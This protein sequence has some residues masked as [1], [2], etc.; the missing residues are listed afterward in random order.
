M[1][2]LITG[3]P[4]SFKTLYAMDLLTKSD[5]L[6]RPVYSNIDG[7]A[8]LPIPNND[9]R[10][11][12]EG[13]LVIYDEAQGL[14]PS[15]GKAG[16][17]N[18]PRIVALDQHRHTGHDIIFITQRYTLIH[19]HI[20]GFVGT[21]YHLVRKTKSIATLYTN[22]EVFNPDDKK[23]IRTV[24]TSIF[25]APSS[26]FNSYKSASLHTK[27]QTGLRFPKWLWFLIFFIIIGAYF[28]YSAIT[29]FLH[30]S[31][32]PVVV[33]A[34]VSQTLSKSFTPVSLA[35]SPSAPYSPDLK[36]DEPPYI[37]KGY[38][39]LKG[40]IASATSCQCFDSTG[41]PVLLTSDLCKDAVKSHGLITLAVQDD[42]HF[43]NHSLN[44]P[45]S[46][47]SSSLPIAA[48]PQDA[49]VGA[50]AFPSHSTSILNTH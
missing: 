19:H 27:I 45:T 17:S 11:T 7:A 44:S 10:D 18:D 5:Y 24:T 30:P 15:T 4:G 31:H 14:F 36:T 50:A 9:W 16:Q 37:K 38:L 28:V 6:N 2:I 40:C 32:S 39:A 35:P 47:T 1:I 8:H 26:L 41:N 23:M 46:N 21:H 13:S 29:S 43:A 25:N 42:T 33:S 22:G 3:V 34:P 20:R 49:R 48:K 12:P